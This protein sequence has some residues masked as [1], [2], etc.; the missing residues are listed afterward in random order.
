MR[1]KPDRIVALSAYADTVDISI[2][3]VVAIEPLLDGLRDVPNSAALARR[4]LL[5]DR[6]R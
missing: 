6:A 5:R 2:E 4:V 3:Q 1:V